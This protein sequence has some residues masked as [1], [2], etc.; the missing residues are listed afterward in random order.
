MI[1]VDEVPYYIVLSCFS[2]MSTG[3]IVLFFYYATAA[4]YC[5]AVVFSY[6]LTLL[7]SSFGTTHMSGLV[8]L[9]SIFWTLTHLSALRRSDYC[10]DYCEY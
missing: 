8:D 4:A 1:E 3:M 6:G 2:F 7:R 9:C 5:P 10:C